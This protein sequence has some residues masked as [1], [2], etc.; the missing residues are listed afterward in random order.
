VHPLLRIGPAGDQSEYGGR[1]NRSSGDCFGAAPNIDHSQAFVKRDLCEWMIWL[2]QHVGFDGW[3]WVPLPG[4]PAGWLCVPPYR[5]IWVYCPQ[6]SLQVARPSAT[7]K[8]L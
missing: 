5:L 1:G 6:S 8:L 4:W 3:R 2:R 7:R